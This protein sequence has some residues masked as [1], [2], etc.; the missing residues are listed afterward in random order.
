M[1]TGTLEFMGN[2][3]LVRYFN[4]T[5]RIR[6]E[7][8]F[9]SL[10]YWSDYYGWWEPTGIVEGTLKKVIQRVQGGPV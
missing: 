3:I 4:N 8:G 10:M 5:W 7:G 9:F 2:D 1:F 6:K